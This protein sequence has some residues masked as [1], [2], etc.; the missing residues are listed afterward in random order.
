[1]DYGCDFK[2]NSLE[3]M[4]VIISIRIEIST[5]LYDLLAIIPLCGYGKLKG[6]VLQHAS[7]CECGL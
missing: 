7:V 4:A 3:Y 2:L 1:M 6:R 5:C